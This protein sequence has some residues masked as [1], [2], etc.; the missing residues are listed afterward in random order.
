MN[1]RNRLEEL[2]TQIL[3]NF[4]TVISISLFLHFMRYRTRKIAIDVDDLTTTPSDYTVIVEGA[5]DTI[6]DN[7]LRDW[8]YRFEDESNNIEIEKVIRTWEISDFVKTQKLKSEIQQRLAQP[9][10]KSKE[11]EHQLKEIE[12][13]LRRIHRKLELTLVSFITFKKAQ[14]TQLNR[15]NLNN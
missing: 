11:Y 12:R 14:R 5:P 4:I 10:V 8:I 15:N 13:D 3:L 7:Q 9:N 1:K 6:D 2:K